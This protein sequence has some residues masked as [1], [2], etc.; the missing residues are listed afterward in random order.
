[1]PALPPWSPAPARRLQTSS[2]AA[3]VARRRRGCASSRA[4]LQLLRRAGRRAPEAN[5][6]NGGHV[7][8]SEG[9]PRHAKPSPGGGG[10]RGGG[11]GCWVGGE[12]SPPLLTGLVNHICS[13]FS[14]GCVLDVGD[15]DDAELHPLLA[16][17]S[18]GGMGERPLTSGRKRMTEGGTWRGGGGG[19]GGE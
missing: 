3:R 15:D 8:S 17:G 7:P 1:V 19:R 11:G 2:R 18:G 10:A 12:V 16:D 5:S 9:G 4:T 13:S 14:W 6:G